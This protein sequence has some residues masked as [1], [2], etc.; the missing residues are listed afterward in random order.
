M[1]LNVIPDPSDSVELEFDENAHRDGDPLITSR[2]HPQDS[3]GHVQFAGECDAARTH[4]WAVAVA[5]AEP[6]RSEALS[7]FDGVDDVLPSQSCLTVRLQRRIQA[8]R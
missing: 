5:N 1:I 8:F 6:L 3:R 4:F 7:L 2:S